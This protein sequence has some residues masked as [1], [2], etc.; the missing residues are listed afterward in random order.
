MRF[1][2]KVEHF[3]STSLD[4]LIAPNTYRLLEYEEPENAKNIPIIKRSKMY[5]KASAIERWQCAI[6]KKIKEFYIRTNHRW[7]WINRTA[8]VIAVLHCVES[9]LIYFTSKLRWIQ[10]F[11]G[12]LKIPIKK[13]FR[14]I[15]SCNS[16]KHLNRILTIGYNLKNTKKKI[17][18]RHLARSR[19]LYMS[20]FGPQFW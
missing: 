2:T 7:C 10:R 19:L 12:S 1:Y 15:I 16:E 17:H 14:F 6:T 4:M 20:T 5:G 3:H 8:W 18:S 9:V 11:G 13:C